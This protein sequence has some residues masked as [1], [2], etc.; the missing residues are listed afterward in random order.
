MNSPL[1]EFISKLGSELE[2]LE[3]EVRR[4]EQPGYRAESTP[5]RSTIAQ[6]AP[7]LKTGPALV[8]RSQWQA[9]S[10]SGDGEEGPLKWS[11]VTKTVLILKGKPSLIKFM[12]LMLDQHR[13]IEANTAE[14][15]LLL[16]IGRDQR[17]DLLVANVKL[18][19]GSGI[20]VARLLRSK[21]PTLPVILTSRYLVKA[22]TDQESADL[23]RLGS[24]S[25][26]VFQE[27][28]Q[29][30]TV[31]NAV[32]ELLGT[33]ASEKAATAWPSP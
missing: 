12:R 18:P 23:K 22:W 33:G 31:Y 1:L 25:V 32:C 24:Q 27:P 11:G 15:A 30:L 20:Y 17:I 19:K 21:I 9:H 7:N 2:T 16:F 4:P 29:D 28:F 14:E 10:S 8:T 5:M 26:V 6:H 13:L 3:A